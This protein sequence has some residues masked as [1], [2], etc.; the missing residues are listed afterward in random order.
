MIGVRSWLRKRPRAV[1]AAVAV[2]VFAYNAPVQGLYVP[3]GLPPG[4]GVLL[5]VGLCAP[6]VLRREFPLS[7]FA[8]VATAFSLQ[9][10]LGVGFIPADVMLLFA[11]HTVAACCL[12]WV[13]VAAAGA[14]ALGVLV[15][16]IGWWDELVLNVG[17]LVT[18]LVLIA[19]VWMWGST[20][21]LRRAHVAGLH[22]RAVRLEKERDDQARIAAAAERARIAREIH[23]VVSH[24][25]SVVV[26][27]AR[28]ASVSVREDPDRAERS[29]ETVEA[30]GRSALAEMRR[31]L[32]VLREDEPGSH[33]PQPGIAQLEQLV[34]DARSS[35][36]PVEFT[37]R[38][39]ARPLPAGT[40]LA[41]YR[42]VQEA[43]TNARRHAGPGVTR[44]EVGLHYGEEEL[45]VH[46]RDD[47][48]SAASGAA[49]GGGHGLVGMRERVAA[50]GGALRTGF[51]SD[52]GFEVAAALPLGRST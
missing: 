49:S 34:A 43:L 22:E 11:L 30:T 6:H 50:Y 35:G 3:Q 18:A 23:D 25:L 47:G 15:V 51:R 26:V 33:A 41:V 2:V 13:S 9:L 21:G 17:D 44:V 37:V 24:G 12:R 27:L 39:T 5:A 36:M 31:M 10:A 46:V 40:A 14:V 20:T 48:R 16:A 42:I 52:G 7:C 38:G 29:L 45:R 8:S 32:D 28:S 4:T 1:D 19:S